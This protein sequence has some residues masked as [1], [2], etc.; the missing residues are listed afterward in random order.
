[1]PEL[2]SRL[3]SRLPECLFDV[4]RDFRAAGSGLGFFRTIA[5]R[6]PPRLSPHGLVKKCGYGLSFGRIAFDFQQT[7][8]TLNVEL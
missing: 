3:L 8:I 1:M 6:Q 5:S 4:T 2:A 7:A